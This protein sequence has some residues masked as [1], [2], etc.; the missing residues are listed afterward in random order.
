MK[1]TF[2]KIPLLNVLSLLLQR[3]P[4]ITPKP[5]IM[6]FRALATFLR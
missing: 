2:S 3:G 4:L 5:Q 6:T 1:T